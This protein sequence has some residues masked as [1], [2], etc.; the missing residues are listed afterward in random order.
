M[1]CRKDIHFKKWCW[2][3]WAAT[4][5]IM[6]VKYSLTPYSKMNS[7]WSK[8]LHG[9]PDTIKL[10]EKNLGRILVG[11]NFHNIFCIHLPE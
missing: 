10:L 4:C 2:E 5:T 1:Q 7:K 11:I 6:N 3:N 9:R 8:D